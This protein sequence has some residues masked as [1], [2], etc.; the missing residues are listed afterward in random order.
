MTSEIVFNATLEAVV[1]PPKQKPL[2]KVGY[3]HTDNL[4]DSGIL[5]WD[6]IEK[7]KEQ[8]PNLRQPALDQLGRDETVRIGHVLFL[9]AVNTVLDEL[10]ITEIR[11]ASPEEVMAVLRAD[12]FPYQRQSWNAF[13]VALFDVREKSPNGH[14]AE[15]L[16]N[17]MRDASKIHEKEELPV[18]I[19]GLRAAHDSTYSYGVRLD[20]H[21]E[22]SMVLGAPA[23]K[24]C[25][26]HGFPTRKQQTMDALLQ[27]GHTIHP[28]EGDYLRVESFPS[29]EG[30]LR[31][32]VRASHNML[33]LNDDTLTN[34][35][36]DPNRGRVLISRNLK[37]EVK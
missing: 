32:L 36:H 22:K 5:G 21:P 30:G 14:Y 28:T 4:L 16:Y 33:Y 2:A 12:D 19:A 31:P 13:A 34:K 11:T 15:H 6:I 18:V 10:G 17:Q 9:S 1:Y 3:F 37:E 24:Y 7:L 35:R 20:F 23:L 25:L 27:E 29:Y 26:S 8:F